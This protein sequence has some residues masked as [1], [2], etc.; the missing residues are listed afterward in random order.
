MR[1]ALIAPLA[2]MLAACGGSDEEVVEDAG[3]VNE[4]SFAQ[5]EEAG[6]VTA[7]DAATNADAGMAPAEDADESDED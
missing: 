1:I 7:I 6:D 5:E 2:L 4:V 3:P